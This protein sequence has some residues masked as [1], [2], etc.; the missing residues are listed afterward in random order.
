MKTPFHRIS[1]VHGLVFALLAA[2]ALCTQ[3]GCRSTAEAT[4]ETTGESPVGTRAELMATLDTYDVQM[5]ELTGLLRES[6]DVAAV[7]ASTRRLI[8]TAVRIVR[9]HLAVREDC[10][11]YLNASLKVVDRMETIGEEAIEN[12]FHKDGALPPGSPHCYHVKDLLV[13]P[14][15]V[16]V[17]LREGGL[18]ERR[19][20][21]LREIMENRAH[22]GAVRISLARDEQ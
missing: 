16:I 21:M 15:T 14:A 19:Q 10:P 7:E 12:D 18:E 17:L 9:G 1:S 2:S 22:L 8:A 13:H 5:T 6:E 11:D 20:D 3:T 4:A